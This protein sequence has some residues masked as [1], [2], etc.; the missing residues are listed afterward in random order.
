MRP[1]PELL[2][3][4]NQGKPVEIRH[5]DV[6]EDDVHL[7]VLQDGKRVRAGKRAENNRPV[8][9]ALLQLAGKSLHNI[10]FVVDN[11]DGLHRFSSSLFR[12]SVSVAQKPPRL[13]RET[14][15][16]PPSSFMRPLT[17][18][19]AVIFSLPSSRSR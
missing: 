15:R 12:C 17:F 7:V 11:Q 10:R 5:T 14:V 2:R 9:V 19:S 16:S 8:P 18:L 1:R 3:L 4:L 13:P 6:G